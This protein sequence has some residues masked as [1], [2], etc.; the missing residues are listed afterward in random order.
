MNS[1]QTLK[2]DYDIQ[3]QIMET[4]RTLDIEIPTL[5]VK[6]HQ[7]DHAEIHK[8]SYEARLNI[9]ADILATKAWQKHK[10]GHDFIHYPASQCSLTVRKEAIT[11]NY[12]PYM[13]TLTSSIHTREYLTR[14]FQWTSAECE[15]IDWYSHGTAIK[16][17]TSSQK[18]FV[19]KFIINW[20]PVNKTMFERGKSPTEN[21]TRCNLEI[22]TE[23]HFLTCKA[24]SH[25]TDHLQSQL[26]QTLHKHKIDPNLR[27]AI[28]QGINYATEV[29]PGPNDKGRNI[30]I[31]EDYTSLIQAQNDIGWYQLWYGR[32][33]MEWDYYQRRYAKSMAKDP[34]QEPTGEPK[35]IRAI[36]LVLWKH[37][38]LRWVERCSYQFGNN[39][40][41]TYRRDHLLDQL[42]SL[43]KNKDRLLQRYHHIFDTSLTEWN[44]K[45]TNQIHEWIIKN[46]P[47]I[48]HG[49]E[50]AK[51]QLKIQAKDI[52]TFY[53]S[54]AQLKPTTTRERPRGS[55][56]NTNRKST[57][58]LN[59]HQDIVKLPEKKTG[60]GRIRIPPS[61]PNTQTRSKD[62]RVMF[63]QKDKRNEHRKLEAERIPLEKAHV[64]DGQCESN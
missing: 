5:H 38:H 62:I 40:D 52:R 34:T 61:K 12:R 64:A 63:T 51:K 28:Y 11:R 60:K 42:R 7:N 23:R 16:S 50:L 53:P 58:Q 3:M 56:M 20:L 9:K 45:T 47:V 30:E 13:R 41:S 33:A 27:R 24:N 49:L 18:R 25:T 4:I 59:L 6:G 57:K 10:K 44:N 17:L 21:C 39:Q 26:R 1:F 22:E 46:G 48:K 15:N 37:N 54:T 14:K 31:P 55:K 36:N 35:W 29:V 8:L 32:W 2:A 19:K 43:Y